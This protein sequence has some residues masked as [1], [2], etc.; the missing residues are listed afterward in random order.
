MMGIHT[1]DEL[2]PMVMIMAVIAIIGAGKI[3]WTNIITVCWITVISLVA[4]V[5]IEAVPKRLKS[6]IDKTWVL[7]KIRSRRYFP[8]SAAK[9]AL[10]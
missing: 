7:S 10:R 8:E 6:R 2:T 9:S 1:S 5:I 4:R 3:I